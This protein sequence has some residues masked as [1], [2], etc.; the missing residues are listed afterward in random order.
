MTVKEVLSKHP[1]FKEFN[2]SQLNRIAEGSSFI[3]FNAGQ[4][5]FKEGEDAHQFY[6][7]LN[8]MVSLEVHVPNRGPVNI[9]RIDAQD[10]LGWSWLYPPHRWHF[11]ARAEEEITALNIDGKFLLKM[12]EEDHEI[13]FNV[14]RRIA[15][16]MEHRLQST[17]L[18][19]MQV[20]DIYKEPVL[21]R[22][23]WQSLL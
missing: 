22:Q 19:L 7:I 13:G 20:Y 23:K 12:I 1:F 3:Q 9:E 2:D 4:F 21:E 5:I 15:M 17:R 16:V 10:V 11:D 8:G 14:I 6:L 18:K